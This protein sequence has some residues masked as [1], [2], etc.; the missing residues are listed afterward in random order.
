MYHHHGLLQTHADSLPNNCY[1]SIT[2][3]TTT[4]RQVKEGLSPVFL[5]VVWRN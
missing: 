1:I 3:T 4:L 5:N 2:T